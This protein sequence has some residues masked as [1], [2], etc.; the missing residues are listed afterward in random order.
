MTT[1]YFEI[2]GFP[3]FLRYGAPI[4]PPLAHRNSTNNT[5]V[6][7]EKNMDFDIARVTAANTRIEIPYLLYGA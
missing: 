5:W 4:A 3:N 7:V 2:D 1:E 6:R